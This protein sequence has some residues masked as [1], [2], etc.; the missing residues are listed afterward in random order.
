MILDLDSSGVIDRRRR[1]AYSICPGDK[2]LMIAATVA[3]N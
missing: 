1:G 3:D 2:T